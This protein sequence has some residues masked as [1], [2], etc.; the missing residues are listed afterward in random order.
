VTRCD[1]GFAAGTTIQIDGHS[2]SV[3]HCYRCSVSRS[4]IPPANSVN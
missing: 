4:F 2:P 1:T 3:R